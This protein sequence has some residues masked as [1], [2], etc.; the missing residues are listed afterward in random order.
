MHEKHSKWFVFIGLLCLNGNY[1]AVYKN[2]TKVRQHFFRKKTSVQ[3][4][5]LPSKSC[6]AKGT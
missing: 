6:N 4:S 2:K 5:L 3:T 1:A